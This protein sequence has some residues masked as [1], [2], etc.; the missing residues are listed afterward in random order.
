MKDHNYISNSEK[1]LIDH[2]TY[3]QLKQ[4]WNEAFKNAGFNG[5]QTHDLRNTGAV[6]VQL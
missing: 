5:I 3:T 4:L 1:D 6:Q 2:H